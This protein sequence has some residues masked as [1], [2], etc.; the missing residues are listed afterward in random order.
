MD[1]GI[2][3]HE[4][5]VKL[6][7]EQIWKGRL[8]HAYLITGPDGIGRRTLAT[9]LVQAINCRPSTSEG[10]PCLSCRTCKNIERMAHPDLAIVQAEQ[11]GGV[12][13]V[14]QVRE[15]QRVLALAPYEAS[16]RAAMLLRFEEA[17]IHA[18]NALLKTLE[19]PSPS[20]VILLTAESA[21]TLLPTV[22][23]RCELLRLRPA[24]LS[25][26]SH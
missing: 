14:D 20:V 22:V 23:S 18:A 25:Q 7:Q 2:I 16:T 19:E 4:W 8:R 17:N 24:G 9:R 15:L 3:G 10:D 12:L 5:A 11:R 21:E 26:V 1:W 13:K 6:L